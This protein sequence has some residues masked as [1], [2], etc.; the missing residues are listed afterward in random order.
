ML[1]EMGFKDVLVYDVGLEAWA[2]DPDLLMERLV[3]YEK[4]VYPRPQ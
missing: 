3:R 4:L 2:A 1:T